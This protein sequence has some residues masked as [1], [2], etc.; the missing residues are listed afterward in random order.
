MTDIQL[1][2]CKNQQKKSS[3]CGSIVL[4]KEISVKESNADVRILTGS[5]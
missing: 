3:N 4:Y 2:Q 1:I 5:S